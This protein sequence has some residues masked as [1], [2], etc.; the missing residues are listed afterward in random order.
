MVLL[1]GWGGSF[2]ET[3]HDPGIDALIGDLGRPVVGLDLLGHGRAAKPHDPAA[4]ADLS[5][6][7]LERLDEIAPVVDVVAFSLGAMTTLGALVRSPERFGRVVL[8]GIGDGTF[9]A[10]NEDQHRR[11]LAA[12]DADRSG[13]TGEDGIDTIALLFAQYARRPG[14]DPLA[15]AAIMRRPEPATLTPDDL[16][17]IDNEVLVVMGDRDFA[18][19][20]DRLAAAFRHGRLA[21]LRNVDHFAT[22][23]A[24]AFLDT[25]LDFLAPPVGA[26]DGR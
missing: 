7:L 18:A 12:I 6:W 21:T 16:S 23:G 11:I 10:R 14:N 1:H 15:L 5:G 22:P 26:P 2:E 19:P 8:A 4:Y 9:A 3:W 17:D 25:V 20:A 13:A 24:F